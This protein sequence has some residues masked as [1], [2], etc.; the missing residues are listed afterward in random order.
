MTGARVLRSLALVALCTT[1]T[2]AAARPALAGGDWNEQGVKWRTYEEG[3][4]EAKTSK[5]PVL[6]IFYTEWC[7]HCANYSKVFH[8]PKVVE[9][10][11]KFV[12]VRIDGDKNQELSKQY[13]ID[14]SYIPRTYVLAPSG[15]VDADIHAPRDQFKFF[16][17]ERNPESVLTA[18]N[19]AMKKYKN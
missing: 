11:K 14:G 5:K 1:L 13:A 8:D 18:M 10:S 9:A 3:L 7:P 4:K 19:A 17:D 12:M 6:L 15:T 2:L 16:Y